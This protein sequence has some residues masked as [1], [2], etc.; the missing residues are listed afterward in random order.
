MI[1]PRSLDSFD[2]TGGG[3]RIIGLI[4]VAASLT[5]S[6]VLLVMYRTL[7]GPGDQLAYDAHAQP[8]LPYVDAYYG[9]VPLLERRSVHEVLGVGWFTA[10]KLVCWLSAAA[11]LTLAFP[12][13]RRLLGPRLAWPA[14]ALVALNPEF[15]TQSYSDHA[16]II[17]AVWILAGVVASLQASEGPPLRWV[18][19]GLLF[20]VALLAHLQA[21]AFIAGTAIGVLML[22][23]PFW[24]LRAARA[25]CF[26]AAAIAPMV[27]WDLVLLGLQGFIPRNHLLM[28]VPGPLAPF[29]GFFDVPLMAE[30]YGALETLIR[31]P[32][33]GGQLALATLR[34]LLVFPLRIG[35]D[36]LFLPVVW[37]LPGV[38]AVTSRPE[39]PGPWFFAFLA[40]LGL[41]AL[42]SPGSPLAYIAL[43]PFFAVL[44]VAGIEFLPGGGPRSPRAISWMLVAGA[45]VLWAPFQVRANFAQVYWPEFTV[46]HAFIARVAD[47]S[48]V[49]TT[50][51][52]SFQ[53]GLGIPF[54]EQTAIMP[55]GDTSGMVERLRDHHVTHLLIVERHSLYVYPELGFLLADTLV[56]LPAGLRRDTLITSP[57]RLAILRVLPGGSGAR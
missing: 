24:K 2:Q 7:S 46:A 42:A 19:P 31:I 28:H 33:A 5:T 54:V 1:A 44:I 6:L 36:L 30:R 57:A 41:T 20:G 15:I 9:L 29:Q 12:L 35:L 23:A 56:G 22:P 4:A 11:L 14:L 25:G 10:G 26:I 8:L 38:V 27:L 18:G 55:R 40:G 43:L 32:G 51:A 47:S 48:T 53:D 16:M 52:K 45:T 34:R 39:R 37:L 17:G 50:T 49:V 3:A 21:A 13:F